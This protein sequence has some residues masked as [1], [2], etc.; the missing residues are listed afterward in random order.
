MSSLSS[1][2]LISRALL[3]YLTH[4]TPDSICMS[5]HFFSSPLHWVHEQAH[6]TSACLARLSDDP[7]LSWCSYELLLHA[8]G[9]VDK[10]VFLLSSVEPI[11]VRPL[12]QAREELPQTPPGRL[13]QQVRQVRG[14]SQVAVGGDAALQQARPIQV[15][16][17][18][19]HM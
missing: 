2:S 7:L 11:S 9:R 13:E 6:Q 8:N 12:Q 18:T 17:R 16:D 3:R 15:Q 10:S 14:R 19:L 4:F 5:I 1:S